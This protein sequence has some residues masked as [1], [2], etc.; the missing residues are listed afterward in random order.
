MGDILADFF[1]SQDF[2]VSS[3]RDG[4]TATQAILSAQP[5]LLLLDQIL[6]GKYGL[7]VL[8]ELRQQGFTEPAILLTNNPTESFDE[9]E[10]KELGVVASFTK[11]G[12]TLPSLTAV[13][14][15]YAPP[16][17]HSTES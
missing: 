17:K 10:L 4:A 7:D 5:D 12:I 9:A 15:R 3:S 8:K 16:T 2:E 14:Q 11:T 13:I 6:P 1:K